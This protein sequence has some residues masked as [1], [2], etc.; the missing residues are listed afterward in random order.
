MNTNYQNSVGDRS[1]RICELTKDSF[2]LFVFNLRTLRGDSLK[3]I[4]SW[5]THFTRHAG[6]GCGYSVTQRQRIPSAAGCFCFVACSSPASPSTSPLTGW[7]R[8]ILGGRRRRLRGCRIRTPP[9]QCAPLTS[10]RSP[11]S[12][13]TTSRP[14]HASPAATSSI[15]VR[16]CD[17]MLVMLLNF[18]SFI[19]WFC[20][21]TC[22][23]WSQFSVRFITG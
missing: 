11:S 23:V 8:R 18:R 1:S 5:K 19:R 12:S 2:P 21:Q 3:R 6:C 7:M 15:P 20:R 16:Y 13:T 14:G 9:S 22:F 4:R 10:S 17:P